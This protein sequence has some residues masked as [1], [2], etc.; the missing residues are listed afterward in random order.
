VALPNVDPWCYTFGSTS[1]RHDQP[2]GYEKRASEPKEKIKIHE[3]SVKSLL[4]K[5]CWP[6]L[7]GKAKPRGCEKRVSEPTGENQNH[8]GS[9]RSL[10]ENMID[11]CWPGRLSQGDVKKS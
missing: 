3:G 9:V 1:P 8:E 11:R 4:G 10:L 6:M 5:Q 7:A 2:R